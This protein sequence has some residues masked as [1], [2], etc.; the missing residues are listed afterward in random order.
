LAVFFI[1]MMF[2]SLFSESVKVVSTPVFESDLLEGI[3]EF[4]SFSKFS[5]SLC[6]FSFSESKKHSQISFS[7]E[8]FLISEI[9]EK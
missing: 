2:N 6:E 1:D 4:I 5:K 3:K 7:M 8:S 9:F